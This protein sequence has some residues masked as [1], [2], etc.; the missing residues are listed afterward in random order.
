MNFLVKRAS[1]GACGLVLIC[2]AVLSLMTQSR[3]NDKQITLTGMVSDSMCGAK[4]MMSGDDAKCI[5]TCVKNGAQYALVVGEKVSPMK[6]KSEDLDKAAGQQ[7]TVTGTLTDSVLTVNS[8]ALAQSS[9]IPARQSA[10]AAD[11]PPPTTIQGLVRDVACPIQNKQTTAR[12]F[13]LKCARECAR[14]GSP[15]IVL[16][17]DG[18]LYTPI[19]ESMPDQD[20]RQRLMPFLGKYVQVTGV[21]FERNGTRAIAIKTIEEVKG[22]QL[23]T[24]AE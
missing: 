5:R 10:T 18:T 21:V 13:N 4:H 9:S 3:A 24:D 22:V 7:A 15:L 11:T 20:Q 16:T 1:V 12:T 23:K 2:L 19:S 14:L 8:V 17:D 6:G